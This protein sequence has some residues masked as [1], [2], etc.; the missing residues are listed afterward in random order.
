MK[1][2]ILT[3]S[4][5]SLIVIAV[6]ACEREGPPKPVGSGTNKHFEEGPTKGSHDAADRLTGAMNSPL[7]Q[8][9]QAEGVV[10]RAADATSKQTEQVSP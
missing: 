7:E 9:N 1:Y 8:A 5:L 6:A 2:T 3:L 4:A 10:Q